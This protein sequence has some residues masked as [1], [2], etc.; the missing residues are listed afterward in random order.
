MVRSLSAGSY[1]S[2]FRRFQDGSD[3]LQAPSMDIGI[4]IL[5]DKGDE[6]LN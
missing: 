5:S 1:I 3:F 6:A 4:V 2:C